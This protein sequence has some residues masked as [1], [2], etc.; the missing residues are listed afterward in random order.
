LFLFIE[1][2][3][4]AVTTE[5]DFGV[6]TPLTTGLE[7]EPPLLPVEFVPAELPA[8]VEP[9]PQA[10]SRIISVPTHAWRNHVLNDIQHSS[11][12]GDAAQQRKRWRNVRRQNGAGVVR[13]KA[14]FPGTKNWSQDSWAKC[15]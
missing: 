2:T 8:V 4:L 9:P 7:P 11:R 10:A 13:E 1:M 6:D 15:E 12:F 5:T 3:Q 14:D